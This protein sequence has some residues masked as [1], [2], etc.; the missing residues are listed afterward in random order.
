[1][2]NKTKA[3]IIFLGVILIGGFLWMSSSAPN[4]AMGHELEGVQATVYKSPSCGCC[5]N[6]ISY[7]RR[8]DLEV[9]RVSTED[10]GTIK[11]QYGI[12]HDMESCH[13][14]VIGD[15]VVEGHIPLEAV[16]RLIKEAPDVKGI[17][18]PGMPSGSPGMMGGKR[19]A[20]NIHSLMHDGSMPMFMEM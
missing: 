2:K 5:D 10:M 8:N 16:A 13:T 1:M 20:F 15:Y 7:L 18:M 4:D 3:I 6:Y 9:E 14:M 17:A 12:P 11:D 19:S